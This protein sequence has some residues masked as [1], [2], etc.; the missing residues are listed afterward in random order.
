M[1]T[2]VNRYLWAEWEGDWLLHHCYLRNMSRYF[3][4]CAESDIKQYSLTQRYFT[5]FLHSWNYARYILPIH[6]HEMRQ[7]AG[8]GIKADSLKGRYVCW[9]NDGK[10]CFKINL[11]KQTMVRYDLGRSGL[12]WRTMSPK[13]RYEWIVTHPVLQR[14]ARLMENMF[15]ED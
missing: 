12:R 1:V 6:V 15:V 2:I 5:I 7:I 11:K 9:H 4:D 3:H 8:E 10:L 14:M 13:Q